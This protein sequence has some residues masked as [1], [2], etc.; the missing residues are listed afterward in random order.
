MQH[1]IEM[2][3]LDI[4]KSIDSIFEYLEEVLDFDDYELNKMVRRAVERE[5]EIIGEALNRIIKIDPL[6]D[7]S[8]IRRIINLRNVIIHAYD[9]VDNVIIWG[10]INKDLQLLK[11]QVN[12]LLTKINLI[13]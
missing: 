10:I 13:E 12:V 6:I 2:Y 3:L 4:N 8:D 7:I 5:L 11:D 1:S 9:N